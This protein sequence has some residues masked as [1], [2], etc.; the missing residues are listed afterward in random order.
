MT[1]DLFRLVCLEC[2][3]HTHGQDDTV[4]VWNRASPMDI[5]LRT[6]LGH[7][8]AVYAVDCDENFIVSG[9]W[10]KTIKVCVGGGGKRRSGERGRREGDKMEEGG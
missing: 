1:E 2:V 8:G 5:I 4:A 9:S 10:D 3:L 6:V 7:T